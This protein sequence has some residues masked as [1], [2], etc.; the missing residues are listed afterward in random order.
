[1]HVSDR[2]SSKM[3]VYDKL[4]SSSSSVTCGST[5]PKKSASQPSNITR[6]LDN[7]EC[8]EDFAIPTLDSSHIAPSSMESNTEPG[9]ERSLKKSNVIK[10]SISS[11]LPFTTCSPFGTSVKPEIRQ[12]PQ[13]TGTVKQSENRITETE[14]I[15]LDQNKTGCTISGNNAGGGDQIIDYWG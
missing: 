15:S 8:D 9:N 10:R 1:M 14:S 7:D 3:S 11:F 2:Q 6:L 5:G 12:D 13:S 4:A